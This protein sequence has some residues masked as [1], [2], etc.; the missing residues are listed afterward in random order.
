MFP[1]GDERT[2][3]SQWP[4]QLGHQPKKARFVRYLPTIRRCC[5]IKNSLLRLKERLVHFRLCVRSEAV[6]FMAALSGPIGFTG[7]LIDIEDS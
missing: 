7:T 2:E 4:L 5:D 3:P 1:S 6:S